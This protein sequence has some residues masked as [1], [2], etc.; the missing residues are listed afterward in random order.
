MLVGAGAKVLGP[1]VIED[2]SKVAANAVVLKHISKNSTAVGIP[3]KVVRQ[4]G[5]KV[6]DLDQVHIPDPVAQEISR[7]EKKLAALSAEIAEL[8]AEKRTKESSDK[9]GRNE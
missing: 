9:N 4:K 5:R 6:D 1:I 2:N 3:A 7:L 8:K